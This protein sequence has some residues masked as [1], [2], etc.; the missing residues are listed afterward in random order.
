MCFQVVRCLSFRDTV[1]YLSEP[2]GER[3]LEQYGTGMTV[4]CPMSYA[5]TMTTIGAIVPEL[6]RRL[7][8][9]DREHYL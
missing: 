3:R 2:L 9:D 5:I 1:L 8:N 6:H 7:P 4:T